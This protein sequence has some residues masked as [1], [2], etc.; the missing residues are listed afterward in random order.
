MSVIPDNWIIRNPAIETA[1]KEVFHGFTPLFSRLLH[2]RGLKTDDEVS[3]FIRPSIKELHDPFMIPGMKEAV[4]RFRRGIE[5]GEKILI[6][7]DYDADGI[8]SSVMVHNLLKLLKIHAEIHIPDRVREGYDL[9]VGHVKSIKGR[10]GL[11]ISVDCGTN[12]IETQEYVKNNQ[13]APDVIACDHHNPSL[14]EYA[15]NKKYIIV[16]P[17]L[18]GST[19]PFKELSGGGVT[20]KFLIAVLR[21][22]DIKWKKPFRKDYLNSLLD[23]VAVST[24]AD[25]MPLTGE[26]RTM[27]IKGLEKIGNSS[28]RGLR[29][30]IDAAVTDKNSIGEFEVGFIIAPRINAAGRVKNAME[31]FKLLSGDYKDC[32]FLAENLDRYNRERQEMQKKVMDEILLKYDFDEIKTTKKIFIAKSPDWNEGILGIA[33][34]DIVKRFNIPAILFRERNG[35]LK[36]SGRSIPGFDLYRNLKSLESLFSKFGGHDMACGIK[37]DLKKFKE[38]CR[39][40][41]EITAELLTKKILLRKY[42]Y[43]MEI[44]FKDLDSGFIE[45][46]SLLKPFGTGNPRPA[47]LSRG[48]SVCSIN[49]IKNGR[50]M[51]IGLKNGNSIFE[52]IIFNVDDCKRDILINKKKISILYNL[53]FNTWGGGKTIQLVLKDLF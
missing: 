47:F 36:G 15:N 26:N 12:N 32:L 16:N 8:I 21:S 52:G 7:G 48:C 25:V 40:M 20:F 14:D 17:K 46:L 9:G 51:K 24:I 4:S 37:M 6:F 43:D 29:A 50:H 53:Q 23:L 1:D 10:V 44:D 42:E 13:D 27:V 38:F 35:I 41:S 49:K 28:N 11:L 19:Y 31:S 45:E 2:L 22:L 3:C 5:S 18:P 34:S 30:L 39:S 33:A